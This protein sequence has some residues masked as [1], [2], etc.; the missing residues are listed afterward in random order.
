MAR[1]NRFF[2]ISQSKIA[3]CWNRSGARCFRRQPHSKVCR[4][5]AQSKFAA[6]VLRWK[7]FLRDF[8]AT[9]LGVGVIIAICCTANFSSLPMFV[10]EIELSADLK[11][12]TN[13]ELY[14]K[15]YIAALLNWLLVGIF[16]IC[17]YQI[18][19]LKY[20]FNDERLPLM[21]QA[22]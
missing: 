3:S 14:F 18:F 10:C 21:K 7:Y 9:M 1:A 2:A 11:F 6:G 20:V 8:C 13:F 15:L 5:R 4:R 22:V 17:I 16:I 19:A 12:C